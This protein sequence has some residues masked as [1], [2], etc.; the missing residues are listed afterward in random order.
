MAANMS[1]SLTGTSGVT[2]ATENAEIAPS[3][4]SAATT[5]GSSG[6]EGGSSSSRTSMLYRES[7]KG[8]AKVENVANGKGIMR[9]LTAS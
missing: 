3:I 2:S 9:R 8:D 5:R 4:R 7:G 1:S 6:S